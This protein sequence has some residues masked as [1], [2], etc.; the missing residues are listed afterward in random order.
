MV[1]DDE[2]EMM[3]EEVEDGLDISDVVADVVLVVVI[4][5]DDGE[6]GEN[7]EDNV[8]E[9][10]NGKVVN[11]EYDCELMVRVEV[12]LLKKKKS[13]NIDVAVVVMAVAV[14]V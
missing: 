3:L 6:G 14:V 11:N 10:L 5:H 9:D 1:D 7:E 2:V 12:V 4:L 8:E 13:V